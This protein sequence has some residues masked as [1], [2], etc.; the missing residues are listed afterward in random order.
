MFIHEADENENV[1]V[2]K[3]IVRFDGAMFS[4]A[5]SLRHSLV[6]FLLI[7]S[8]VTLIS[9]YIALHEP[10][11]FM[12]CKAQIGCHFSDGKLSHKTWQPILT[13]GIHHFRA[14]WDIFFRFGNYEASSPRED[15]V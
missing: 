15:P 2:S 9:S 5:A 11:L 7:H 3:Q 10:G 12:L 4:S 13:D 6:A 8:P 1:K 14:S